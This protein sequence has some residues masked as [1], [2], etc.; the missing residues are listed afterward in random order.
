MKPRRNG[1]P[2]CAPTTPKQGLASQGPRLVSST[3]PKPPATF[4][5]LFDWWM[6]E[7][8]SRLRGAIGGF[9]RKR[10]V[11]PL[12][13]VP[14]EEVTSARIEELLQHQCD[15]LSP[16]SL[17]E[18]RGTLHRIFKRAAQRG[19]WTGPNPATTV[20]K[21][22]VP[23]KLFDTLRADEVPR[24]LAALSPSW[25]P[26][27]AA[28]IWTGMRKGELL[29]LQKN[30][31]DFVT[32]SIAVRRS[33]DH[34]TTKG[35]HA[36]LLPIAAQLRP[37][38]EEAIDASRCD[39]VFPNEEGE[40]RTRNTKLQYVLG[41]ALAR[42]GLVTAYRHICRRSGC[43]HREQARDK[44]PR[45]CPKCNMKL[46]ARG[47]P[48][49]LRFHDLRATTATLLARAGVPLVIAQRILRHSDP[50]LT[51]NIYSRVD[52]ADLQA[53]IDRLGI[54]ANS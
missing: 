2:T 38:L 5:E 40:M 43:G 36:D 45:R 41:G 47:I 8:G 52:L 20:E 23:R 34:E 15:E 53:G 32:S 1:G 33:Y 11:H 31:V 24:L 3:R 16:K 21:R 9:L 6:K 22:K 28:A 44:Q 51:A 14:V 46:L 48:R 26:L 7:Y 50:R 19:L 17:N 39:L 30:D 12:S 4:D 35:G 27:F 13:G 37:Y 49:R 54:R 18:L 42:A 25:R 10:L 29:G